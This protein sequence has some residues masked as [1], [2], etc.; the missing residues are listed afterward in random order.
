MPVVPGVNV[1]VVEEPALGPGAPTDTSTTFL[2]TADANGPATAT[3][4]TSPDQARADFPT[5]TTLHAEVDAIQREGRSETGV[6]LV[7]AIKLDTAV[8]G[9]QTT[10][11]KI[12]ATLGPGQVVAPAVVAS[13][14]IITVGE[15]AWTSNRVFIANAAADATD[16][17]LSTLA[18][19]VIASGNGRNVALFADAAI[20]PGIGASTRQVPWSLVQAG[21]IARNDLRTGNPALAAAGD[22]GI[23]VYALGLLAERND[24]SM[25]TLNAAKVNVARAPFGGAPRG[26]GYRTLADLAVLPQWWDLGGSRVVMDVRSNSASS[27]ERILFAPFDSGGQT[28]AKWNG[29]LSDRCLELLRVGALF[30]N[31]VDAFT[32]DTGVALN[33]TASLAAGRGRATIRLKTAPFAES[34]DV[35]IVRQKIA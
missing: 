29:L 16:A 18:A 35:S 12:P 25:T 28:L 34:L 33:P 17:Q 6:P 4:I 5:A 24:V 27:S 23:A 13:A 9:L 21:I 19:A 11:D 32:V 22:N 20:I 3:R 8:G 7:Q 26:Y 10:L 1:A 31:P 15:W 2:L 30:G 14:D